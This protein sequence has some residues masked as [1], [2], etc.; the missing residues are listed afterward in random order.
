VTGGTSGTGRATARALAREGARALISGRGPAR[1]AG[2]AAAIQAAGGE[3]QFARAGLGPPGDARALAGRAAGAGILASNAGGF[4]GGPAHAL[5][6]AAF[7]Q[8]CTVHATAPFLCRA[9][10]SVADGNRI[11]SGRRPRR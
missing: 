1:G 11:S 4:P 2:V 6:E 8:T 9:I 5:P 3:A 7:D 10:L